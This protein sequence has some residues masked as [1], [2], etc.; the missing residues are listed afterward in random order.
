MSEGVTPVR[1]AIV[2]LG[3]RADM[4]VDALA[5]RF[6]ANARLV[7]LCDTNETRMGVHNR[8]LVEQH[9]LAALPTYAPADF[10]EMLSRERVDAVMI[11]TTDSAHDDYLV[12]TVEAGLRAVT[13]KPMTTDVEKA[14]R[15]LEAQQRTGGRIEVTFNY[16]YNP[17]HQRVRELLAEKVIGDVGSV[18]FEWLLDVQHGA[19]Y[20]RRWHRNRENSGGLLVHKS[21]H[22]FDLVNWWLGDAPDSV[23][24]LG[25]L[26]FYGAE[27]G[28]RTG[29]A[30]DYA[31][32]AGSQA[33]ATDPF[34]LDMAASPRLTELYLDAEHEDGYHRDRNVFAGDIDIEDDMSVLARYR[35]GASLTYQLTAYAPYEG[36]RVSFNGTKGRLELD[37]LEN[38]YARS[39]LEHGSRMGATPGSVEEVVPTRTAITLRPLFQPAEVLL[40]EPMRPGHGG[41][42]DLMLDA[43]FGPPAADPLGLRADHVAGARALAI[44]LAATKSF[45]TGGLV[46]IADLL[47][48]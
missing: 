32:A 33:A 23:V 14:R 20:F 6:P 37:V 31:R 3:S 4:Y 46:R 19:D 27:G 9:G 45:G 34:A 25:N 30:K 38:D 2:G 44:G 12:A 36:Y 21:S 48:I 41:G 16:R 7:A 35:G 39:P 47:P 29:Y 1:Y 11:C 26:F 5:T 8:R 28:A 18:H 15:I 24:G 22:H 42:D 10:T 40:D 17:V 13:E 43:L